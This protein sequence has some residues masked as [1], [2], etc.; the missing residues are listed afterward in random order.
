[1]KEGVIAIGD[2][3]RLLIL[4][5]MAEQLL[6]ITLEST[7]GKT[8]QEAIRNPDLQRFFEQSYTSPTPPTQEIE[9]HAGEARLVQVTG[10]PLLDADSKKIGVLVVLNDVTQ[11]RRLENI[12]KD[13]VANV[14]HELKTPITSIKGFVETL[15]E[16][17]IDDHDK[18]REIPG[19]SGQAGRQAECDYR[20]PS[21][22]L[23]D[24]TVR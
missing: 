24:R 18:A 8:L 13:F 23:E 12:R 11:T 5:P 21:D 3:D 17:A 4:N 2:N 19:N 1:M 14:S 6:G 10:T 7:K 15:R 22:A 20:G 9:I 16:G